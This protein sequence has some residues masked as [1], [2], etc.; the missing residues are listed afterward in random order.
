MLLYNKKE[1]RI[2]MNNYYRT[3][4][5][6]KL[7]KYFPDLS[8]IENLTVIESEKDFEDNKDYI[9][10][11]K[12]NRVD[13]LKTKIN[14]MNSDNKGIGESFIEIFKSIKSKDE[15]AVLVLFNTMNEPSERYQRYA[16]IS[17]GVEL[18]EYVKIDAV[19]KGFDGREVSKNMY[20]HERYDIPWFELRNI[21]IENF[22]KYRTYLTSQEEYEKT[23][24]E[25][26]NYLKEIG[27]SKE[28]VEIEVPKKYM[29]IPDFIWMDI[30]KN[31]LKVLE[32]EEDVLRMD[33]LLNFAI[34][35]H[36]EGKKY[37]PW[38]LFDKSRAGI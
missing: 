14:S 13:T 9:N 37:M 6:I 11:L 24:E 33:G 38:Q 16:G 29:E 1:D 28:V 25:R 19:G 23:R 20:T 10:T 22:K 27:F 26:I 21:T 32:K 36:T 3:S 17:I 12:N 2:K 7:L 4:D 5:M 30:I 18:G 31:F 8:P 34:S 35:G 15:D